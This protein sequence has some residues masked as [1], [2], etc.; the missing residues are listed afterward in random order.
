MCVFFH[1]VRE[2]L[3]FEKLTVKCYQHYF[4]FVLN[5][6]PVF[7][8]YKH[9]FA[10]VIFKEANFM[11]LIE[12]GIPSFSMKKPYYHTINIKIV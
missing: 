5:R 2:S 11:F 7:C 6:I 9:Y 12:Q 10:I 8:V 1:L 4:F 3:L